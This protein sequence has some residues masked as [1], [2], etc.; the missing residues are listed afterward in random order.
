MSRLQTIKPRVATI[1]GRLHA[2]LQ[3]TP[4]SWR[5]EDKQGSSTARGYTYKWQQASN[6]F[7]RKHPLCQCPDCDEGRK[8]ITPSS[9]VDHHI[10]HR[11]DMALFWD[12]SNWR[13]LAKPCHDR[14]TQ[15]E[16]AQDRGAAT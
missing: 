5:T 1:P 10:P 16:L 13:A 14:K 2:T 4:G 8:R 9:V 12:R 3:A 7:L 11:G 6:A 15:H